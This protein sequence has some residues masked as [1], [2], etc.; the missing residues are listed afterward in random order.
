V[1]Y[2]V[3]GIGGKL[4][5]NGLNFFTAFIEFVGPLRFKRDQIG[6]V[7]VKL[8]GEIPGRFRHR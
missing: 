2:C 5:Q 1:P 3:R 6:A 8:F 4:I 7:L